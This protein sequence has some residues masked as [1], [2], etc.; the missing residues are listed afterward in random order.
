MKT[1]AQHSDGSGL[2]FR[3][4]F[5]YGRSSGGTLTFGSAAFAG[6][7]IT[8]AGVQYHVTDHLGTVVAVVKGS[9][10]TVVESGKYADFGSRTDIVS[11]GTPTAAT[12]RWHFSGKE[13][14]GVDFDLPFTDFGARLY[15]PT[16]GRW[17]V[18]DPASEKYY[19][20]S[21]YAY[22]ANDPV[23][24]VDPDGESTWVAQQ[25]D[26]TYKVIGGDLEDDDLNIYVYELDEKGNPSKRGA[27]IGVTTSITSFFNS[28]T[29]SWDVSSII[30]L[31]DKS[32]KQFLDRVVD[33]KQS[34]PGYA[35]DARTGH[36]NDF[37]ASNNET[38]PASKMNPYRGMIVGKTKNGR[39]VIT[40]ARDIGNMAAGY[41]AGLAGLSW[42]Q[43]R[44]C[45]DTYQSIQTPG[46]RFV[47]EGEST[48]N[49]EYLGWKNGYDKY[50]ESKKPK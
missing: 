9:D 17:I 45:F 41:K 28:D 15:A 3:G 43:T 38:H 20:I 26:G 34:L 33:E 36:I 5:V 18:P 4:P 29:N 46:I 30:D 1:S 37:K 13:N 23:N 47:S 14:Q 6:G 35:L 21:P 2:V 7:R 11:A 8:S 44:M 50:L 40:S 10:G 16:F 48:Q 24:L 19:D 31:D 25:E 22:C 49:A 32:G 39:D 42:K 27:S 12:N